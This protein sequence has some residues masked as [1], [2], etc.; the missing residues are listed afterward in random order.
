MFP[1][2]RSDN[3][4]SELDEN[5]DCRLRYGLNVH[6]LSQIF[7]S[8]NAADLYTLGSMNGFYRQIIHENVISKKE[9]DFELLKLNGISVENILERHASRVQ[10]FHFEGERERDMVKFIQLVTQYCSEDQFKDVRFS[11]H[12]DID[13]FESDVINI[14]FPAQFAKMEKFQFCGPFY[15]IN[16]TLQLHIPFSRSLQYL[17]LEDVVLHPNINWIDAA[18]L[19]QIHL[20]AIKGLNVH[21]FIDFLRQRPKLKY[22]YQSNTFRDS[23]KIVGEAMAEYCGESLRVYRDLEYELA[24]IKTKDSHQYLSGFKNL[25]EVWLST[26][27]ICA[28]D[29]FSAIDRLADTKVEKL[30]IICYDH[31]DQLNIDCIFTDE[32]NPRP[33]YLNRLNYLKS[34]RIDM[35]NGFDSHI[36][37]CAQMKVLTMYSSQILSNVENVFLM[38]AQNM[39]YEYGFIETVPNLRLLVIDSCE[40]GPTLEKAVKL[41]SILRSILQSRNNGQTPDDFIEL[42]INASHLELFQDVNNNSSPIK[43]T[44]VTHFGEILSKY[45]TE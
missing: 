29:L 7:K 22:F 40:I 13:I 33:L 41:L 25:N 12:Y 30:V 11:Y 20:D 27:Q 43:I 23:M 8:L 19:E 21:N 3:E 16:L 15:D 35:F 26:R 28:G 37:V 1:N 10:K 4:K 39:A 45:F 38:G 14:S 17:K 2:I 18:N 9:I 36:D 5:L 6:C 34:I 32:F 31:Y 44:G 42:K 24:D